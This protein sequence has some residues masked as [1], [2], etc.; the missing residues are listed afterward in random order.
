MLNA[1]ASNMDYIFFVY[2]LSF[3]LLGVECARFSLRKKGDLAWSYLATFGFFHGLNEWLSVLNLSVGNSSLFGIIHLSLI[4]FSF[5]ALFEFGRRGVSSHFSYKSGRWVYWPIFA[6]IALFAYFEHLNGL[7]AA[8]RY[9]LALPG[10]L[11]AGSALFLA[12]S[13]TAVDKRFGLKLSALAIT[14]FGFAG[15][16]V[17]PRA[18]FF[19]AS[20]IN[21]DTFLASVGIP[22]QIIKAA[23]ALGAVLGLWIFHKQTN[24]DEIKRG[25]FHRLLIPSALALLIVAGWFTTNWRATVVDQTLRQ[26][27]LQQV[28]KIAQVIN[29]ASLQALSFSPKDK[30]NPTYQRLREQLKA[31]GRFIHQYEIYSVTYHNGEFLFGP[32]TYDEGNPLA[33]EPGTIY[34]KPPPQLFQSAYKNKEPIV[35]GP[36]TDE[37]GSFVSSFAPVI[38]QNTGKVPLIVGLDIS[39]DTW[40]S[41]IANARLITIMFVLGLTVLLIASLG[42]LEWRQRL[43]F[44]HQRWLENTE[45]TLTAASGLVLTVVFVMLAYESEARLRNQVFS[46]LAAIKMN[47][48]ENYLKSVQDRLSTLGSF[49]SVDE[50]VTRREFQGF[51]G[52]RVQNA[53]DQTYEWI[54]KVKYGEKNTVEKQVRRSGFANFAIYERDSKGN[55][56]PVAV[57]DTYFPVLYAEP[58][59]GNESALGFDLGSEITRRTALEK[60]ARTG[61]MTATE[62]IQLVQEKENNIGMLV[63]EPVYKAAP[64]VSTKARADNDSLAGFSVAV[65]R[66]EKMMK[67]AISINDYK[68]PFVCIDMYKLSPDGNS[69]KLTSSQTNSAVGAASSDISAHDKSDELFCNEPVF[70]FGGAYLVVGYPGKDFIAANPMKNW[71]ITLIIGTIFTAALTIFVAS[72]RNRQILLEKTVFA[73][74]SEL[75][76]SETKYRTLIEN[77]SDAIM[78]LGIPGGNF[79]SGNRAALKIFNV[80]SV[81]E[82][83]ALDP[84]QLSPE[85]Q[86]NG[87]LSSLK[88]SDGIGNA[89]RNGFYS[90]EWV[91]KRA[92]GEE[93]YADVL[94]TRMELSGEI[95]IQ[96]TVR[97]IT[98]RKRMM[99]ELISSQKAAE[100]S[101]EQLIQSDKLAAIGTL[102]AGVA[103][104]I[105]NPIGYISSNLNTMG[106]YLDK[107]ESHL[108]NRTEEDSKVKEIL[109]DF[110]DAISESSEGASRVKRIVADLKSFARTDRLQK[111]Y[112]NINVGIESTL[113]IVW[114]ELKYKCKIE[115]DFGELPD[116]YCMPN[117]LNQVFMNLLVNAGQSI[118]GKNGLIIIKTWA[119]NEFINI[120]IRDNGCGIPPENLNRIFEAFFTTKEVGQGTGLGL[121]LVYD[122]ITKHIGKIEVKSEVGQGSE[123]IVKL[124]LPGSSAEILIDE[125]EKAGKAV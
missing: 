11:L 76:E 5:M 94:L 60:A 48:V 123:F 116:F 69:I 27:M 100:I 45:S 81:E 124:P 112:A 74:T 79:T 125:F 2:G 80:K 56:N 73:R 109:N 23:C 52:P 58:F 16:I 30:N 122:I 41:Q 19:P 17:V 91:H 29:P 33:S 65:L 20:F 102:A 28:T 95:F 12:S 118:T 77:S 82:F 47:F 83:T 46:Q 105:N 44:G 111:E 6:I 25:V 26:K 117:Q 84:L 107:I 64:A 96:A 31:Y 113:N 36:Y 115:K 40:L 43:P 35:I 59:A 108:E 13:R 61:L 39:A 37:Y 66:L 42:A 24:Q 34:L 101:R 110:R 89:I 87:Q 99:E 68:N 67:A 98:E 53:S 8:F 14:L 72:L 75:R 78:T 9:I 121:S 86:P 49:I 63:F 114:N 51:M 55:H 18:S 62:P 93:F 88:V 70:I 54:P 50:Y 71:W 57:R 85:R 92:G 10:G 97:D 7:E 3:I 1:F 119:D 15:G 120:S 38:D 21:Y 32:E 103:H 4:A 22:I 106:K 104:E 90:F